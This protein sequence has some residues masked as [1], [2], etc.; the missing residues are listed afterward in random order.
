MI[1]ANND[2]IQENGLVHAMVKL[3]KIGKTSLDHIIQYQ[4]GMKA[5]GKIVIQ[6]D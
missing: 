6:K 2:K 5:T 1:K 4:K 3:P